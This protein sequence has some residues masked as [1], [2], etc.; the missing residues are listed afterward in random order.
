VRTF[1]DSLPMAP[2]LTEEITP[3]VAHPSDPAAP[4]SRPAPAQAGP[5]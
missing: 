4:G 1:L 5:S 2:W 3:L